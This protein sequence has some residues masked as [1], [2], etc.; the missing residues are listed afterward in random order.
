MKVLVPIKRVPDYQTKVKINSSGVG[1]ETDNIKWIVNPF[2]EIAVEEAIKLKD[3]GTVSEIVVVTVGPDDASQQLRYAMAM[4][5]DR[6]IIVK[7][8]QFVDSDL[9]AKVLEGVFKSEDFGFIIMGKQSI[10]SDAS[11]TGQLL[12]ERLN[13]AQACFASKVVIEAGFATVTREIDGGLETIKVPMPCVITTDLRLNQ[14]RYAS[15]PGIMKAK[16]KPLDEKVLTD[17]VSADSVASVKILSMSYPAKRQAGRKVADVAELVS[18][19]K[20]EVKAL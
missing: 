7:T 4:G 11:Q 5:A 15:L 10:D 19:L 2:D 17:F 8:D 18:V 13:I 16:K 1:I 14:P 6:G 12:A 20:N 9:A 3:A